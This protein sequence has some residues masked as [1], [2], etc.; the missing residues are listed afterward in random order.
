MSDER[1]SITEEDVENC[2]QGSPMMS[3]V[4]ARI[5]NGDYS[6]SEAREDL[7]GLIGS[8]WDPRTEGREPSE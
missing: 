4:I 6:V 1:E 3:F 2:W 7:L 5:L 8:Q